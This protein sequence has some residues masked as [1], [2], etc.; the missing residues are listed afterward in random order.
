MLMMLPFTFALSL[1]LRKIDHV[2]NTV[3][4]HDRTYFPFSEFSSPSVKTE[5]RGIRL[6]PKAS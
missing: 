1:T 5:K 3:I 2:S 4:V 6:S